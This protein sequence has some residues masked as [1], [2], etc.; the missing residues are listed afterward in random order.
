M[1]TGTFAFDGVENHALTAV[2][3][4]GVP[5]RVGDGDA[6]RE[7]VV[8]ETETLQHV[9]HLWIR[10]GVPRRLDL[11]EQTRRTYTRLGNLLADWGENVHGGRVDLTPYVQMR[12]DEGLG[13]RTVAMELRVASIALHWAR[14]RG[15]LPDP[16]HIY[17]PRLRI[18]RELFRVNHRT[19]SPEE[20]TR[21][22][23]AMPDDD[24]KLATTVL[25]RTGARIGEVVSLRSCDLDVRAKHLVFGSI[26]GASKTGLRRFP[27]DQATLKALAP[28]AGKGEEALFDFGDTTV[29]RL[30]L[31][32]RLLI[33]CDIAG[34]PAFTPHGLRRMVVSRLIRSGIDPGTAASITGHSV[35]VMLQCYQAV[36]DEDR[37]T[38]VRKAGLSGLIPTKRLRHRA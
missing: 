26:P 20:A 12:L 19:P 34:V 25:A 30:S 18:E 11:A 13:P 22:I 3:D 21:A 23:A 10:D 38:A 35:R 9:M 7:V 5:A 6:N 16:G 4:A 24:W 17:I 1:S 28:R 33:A 14:R 31:P 27:L 15:V 36:T 2:E 37:R 32:R 8:N 29:P